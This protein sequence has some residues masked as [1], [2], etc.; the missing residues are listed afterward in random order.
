MDLDDG[1]ELG[2]RAEDLVDLGGATLRFARGAVEALTGLQHWEKPSP[3]PLRL[4]N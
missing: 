3:A 1:E 4:N 2:I